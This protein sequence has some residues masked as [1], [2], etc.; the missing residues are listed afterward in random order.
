MPKKQPPT[1][2]P[3]RLFSR[4][5]KRKSKYEKFILIFFTILGTFILTNIIIHQVRIAY[6]RAQYTR[7]IADLDTL[8]DEIAA[9]VG[10]ADEVKDSRYCRYSSM[11]Y[12]KGPRSCY[13]DK[14]LVYKN[15]TEVSAIKLS[16]DITSTILSSTSVEFEKTR[17][18]WA[19]EPNRVD[20]TS[21]TFSAG[22]IKG[23]DA[24]F[25][26]VNLEEMEDPFF[27]KYAEGKGLGVRFNCSGGSQTEYFPVV[28]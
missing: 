22:G 7:A 17:P 9:K 14:Y 23:C 10:P 26:Y 2:N 28:K 24:I 4:F 13:V 18:L 6:E 15:Q 1:R 21:T 12:E 20:F 5:W 25:A 3:L 27:T 16:R 8:Y 19:S 11:K